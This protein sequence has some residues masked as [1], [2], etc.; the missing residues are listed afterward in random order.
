M[1][2]GLFIKTLKLVMNNIQKG[3]LSVKMEEK[4]TNLYWK[5][6]FEN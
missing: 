3:T 6:I 5:D 1:S 4:S 2:P